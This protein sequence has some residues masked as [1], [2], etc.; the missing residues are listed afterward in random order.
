MI[1]AILWLPQMKSGSKAEKKML[2]EVEHKD[3]KRFH[4]SRS[5]L[6]WSIA[7]MTGFQ[8]MIFIPL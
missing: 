4:V 7:L 8:S 6:A 3:R 2:E 5:K 1:A